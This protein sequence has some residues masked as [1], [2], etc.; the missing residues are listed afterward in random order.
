MNLSIDKMQFPLQ[1]RIGDPGLLVGRK[2]EFAEYHKWVEGIP[3]KLSK[4]QVMLARKKS[5]KTAFI[6]ACST[7][8]G[9]PTAR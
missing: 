8:Y 2:A 6:P 9:A 1:E 5:G 7:S 3:R 4:S